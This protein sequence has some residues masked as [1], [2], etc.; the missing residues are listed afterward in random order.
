MRDSVTVD[1]VLELLNDAL[2][3]DPLAMTELFEHRVECVKEL[4]DHPTI[5]CVESYDGV[6][7]YGV[8]VLGL[9]NGLFGT[10]VRGWGA[11]QMV[12]DDTDDGVMIR[13][14]QRTIPTPDTPVE[15]D[16]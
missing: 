9:L 6:G 1:Q 3:L 2:A 10:D 8:G 13:R 15:G 16:L 5:Q 12:V 11:L 14:F 7:G 4:A